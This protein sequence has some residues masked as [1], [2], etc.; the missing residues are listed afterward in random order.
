M[1]YGVYYAAERR[2][3]HGSAGHG[4][5]FLV[6]ADRSEARPVGEP[7]VMIGLLPD[8]TYETQETTIPP[9]STLYVLSDGAYEIVT[10][11]DSRWEL[12]D[13]VPLLTEPAVPGVTD[14]DRVYQAVKQ[15]AA[16][17]PLEDDFSLM[18]LT[19]P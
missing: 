15:A 11:D 14:P 19:F 16:P 10:K 9:G 8:Q 13:F 2:L 18:A 6:P 7:A 17:G 3:V 5:A 12:S 1:W 4:P